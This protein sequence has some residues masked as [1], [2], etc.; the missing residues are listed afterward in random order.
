MNPTSLLFALPLASLG[1]GG[2]LLTGCAVAGQPMSQSAR[3]SSTFSVAQEQPAAESTTSL[4]AVRKKMKTTV[5]PEPQVA[6]EPEPARV[7]KAAPKADDQPAP[8]VAAEPAS[9]S[10]PQ[11]AAET[12]PKKRGPLTRT[13][14]KE[15]DNQVMP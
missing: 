8:K 15:I 10:P 12:A 14:E 1:L 9:E 3:K 5:D 2:F 6:V 4:L 11:A 7:W 13:E